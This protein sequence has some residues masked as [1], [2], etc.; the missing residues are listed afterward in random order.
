MEIVTKEEKPLLVDMVTN[1]VKA[2]AG[3]RWYT[4]NHRVLIQEYWSDKLN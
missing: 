1:D 2:Y 4:I 3:H